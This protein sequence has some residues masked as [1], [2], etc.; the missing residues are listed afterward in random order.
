MKSKSDHVQTVRIEL[1]QKEREAL[2]LLTATIAARNVSQTV[3]NVANGVNSVISP[4]LNMS[5]T[6]GLYFGGLI[7]L[8]LGK[9]VNDLDEKGKTSPLT[10][11]FINSF[12]PVII[13]DFAKDPKAA[14]LE[15]I[16]IMKD[17]GS[18]F[19]SWVTDNI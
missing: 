19:K 16:Q 10:S 7:T 5:V 4:F 11:F 6:S 14:A 15:R 13:Y 18:G 2:E 12:G 1:Q 9:I 17:L 8:I 3:S